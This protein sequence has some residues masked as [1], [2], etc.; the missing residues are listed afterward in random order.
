MQLV[1]Q[2]NSSFEN[3]HYALGIFIDLSKAC[4]TVAH[5]ILITKLENME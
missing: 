2:I 4:D 5:D 3:I 1:D